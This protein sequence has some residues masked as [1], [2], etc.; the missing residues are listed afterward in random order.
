MDTYIQAFRDAGW[1]ITP[2]RRLIF[3][4]LA[5]EVDHP[6]AEE[7]YQRAVREMPDISRSTVY[8]TL[9]ALVEVGALDKVQDVSAGGT[10]YDTEIDHHHH[11]YCLRCGT[12][13]DVHQTFEGLTL[14]SEKD[15]GYQIVRRQVTFYGYCPECRDR[16]AARAG[17]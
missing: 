15:Q 14:A 1:R 2:Q 16:T 5:E 8:N 9:N 11:L 17:R 13:I 12:L 10:R 7:V 3:E 6:M 4:I